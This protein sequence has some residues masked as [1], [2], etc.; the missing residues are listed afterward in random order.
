VTVIAFVGAAFSPA[1][2]RS[3]R[4][5]LAVDPEAHCAF[6]VVVHGRKDAWALSE[7][8][9]RDVVRERD[10][11]TLG[12][13]RITRD[14]G[15]IT[16]DVDER[17]SP[18]SAGIRGRI[19]LSPEPGIAHPLALDTEG[20]HGWWPIAPRARIEVE[21]DR[22]ALRFVGRGYHDA[23]AGSE[24]LEL[25]FVGWSWSRVA[26]GD[27]TLVLYDVE[28]RDA[29][30]AP[31][32]LAFDE[33]GTTPIDGLVAQ[34]LGPTRWRLARATRVDPG[35]RARIVRTLVDAP[36]YSRSLVETTIDARRIVG[37]HE[38]VDLRRF[39][40]PTTQWMLPFRI[41]GVG[42]R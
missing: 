36:F 6:H 42:W 29:P 37:V 11:I 30:I 5:Q 20:R 14:G 28:G 15:G 3:R 13:S 27:R 41:N 32:G 39:V 21:L 17:A 7:W 23:N 19:R 24:A 22:P 31:I 40:R 10:A 38:V 4:A 35:S 1:Y 2:F 8:R 26:H 33:C 12:R 25:A 34:D 18:W 9:G 16:I